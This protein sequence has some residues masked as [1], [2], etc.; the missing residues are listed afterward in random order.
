MLK[1]V[2]VEILTTQVGVTSGSLHG[3][4]ATSD[5]EERNIEGTSTQIEDK[6]MLLL[7]RL[8]VK[9]VGNCSSSRLV[10]DTEDLKTGNSTCILGSKTLGVV[11][12]SGDTIRGNLV[13][14][15]R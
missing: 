4:N 10:D 12:V 13:I 1:E 9:T 2:V 5:V 3:E 15:S 6:D 14:S 11:E 7:R 8:L